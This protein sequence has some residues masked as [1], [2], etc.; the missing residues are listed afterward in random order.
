MTGPCQRSRSEIT[1]KNPSPVLRQAGVKTIGS[2][3]PQ[4]SRLRPSDIAFPDVCCNQKGENCS[5][6]Q[7][8]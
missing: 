7:G 4:E 6:Y 1:K 2:A 5:E 3:E 8:I